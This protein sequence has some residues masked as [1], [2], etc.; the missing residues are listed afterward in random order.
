MQK[1]D[2]T[3]YELWKKVGSLCITLLTTFS[4]IIAIINGLDKTT[5]WLSTVLGPILSQI[6]I[7]ANLIV[8][9]PF[10]VVVVVI[11]IISYVTRQY[12]K[13]MGPR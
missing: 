9:L 13:R 11:S 6:L 3:K 12:S 8:L 10:G 2:K 4:T 7:Y 1:T 5:E